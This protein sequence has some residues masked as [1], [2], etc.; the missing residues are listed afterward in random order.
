MSVFWCG[1]LGSSDAVI[2]RLSGPIKQ[3]YAITH[4]LDYDELLSASQYKEQY[5]QDMITWS[6]D[7]RNKQPQYFIEKAVQMFKGE[8][9]SINV[10]IN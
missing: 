1:R 7:I 3:Q 10:L 4:G 5:R 2:V 8:N 6:E 9:Y